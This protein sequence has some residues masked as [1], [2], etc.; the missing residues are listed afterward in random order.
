MDATPERFHIGIIDLFSIL[1]P[2]AI[3]A[4]AIQTILAPEVFAAASMTQAERWIALAIMAYVIGHFV[5]AAGSLLDNPYD[6]A[7][8]R[9]HPL[10]GDYALL[11][12]IAIK[13]LSL[14]KIAINKSAINTFQWTKCRLAM[15]HPIALAQIQRYEAD[16]KFFRSLFVVLLI[17]AIW[18]A[19]LGRWYVAAACLVL[20]VASVW[21][22]GDQRFKA[23]RQAYWYLITLESTR[24]DPVK[25][26]ARASAEKSFA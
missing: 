17:I 12:A 11:S 1:L 16:S 25:R 15:A 13:D 26:A 19:V 23:T 22:Y 4:Y 5:F 24:K 6:R 20:T 14:E 2:G 10:H 8:E 7:R 21:R 3:L 9:L 18:A